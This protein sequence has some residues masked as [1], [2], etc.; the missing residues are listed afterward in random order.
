L[1]DILLER[2]S[3]LQ[4]A[5]SSTLKVKRE[6]KGERKREKLK[7]LLRMRESFMG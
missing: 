2:Q 5:G 1:D 3:L 7:R 6:G 4:E